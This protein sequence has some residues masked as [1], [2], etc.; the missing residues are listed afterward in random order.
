VGADGL[1]FPR[2]AFPSQRRETRV[3][4]DLTVDEI[5]REIVAWITG[6]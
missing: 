3:V 2:V 5:A 6:K 4:K 1:T